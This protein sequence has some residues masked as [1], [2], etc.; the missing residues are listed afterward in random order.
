MGFKK[1][2][3][4]T[5]HAKILLIDDDPDMR[6]AMRNILADA[7]FSVAEA[8]AGGVGLEIAS[9]RTPDTVLLDMRMPGLGG[10]E[11]LRRLR[12]LDPTLPVII[13]TAHGTISGAVSAV[14]DGAFDYLTKPFRNEHLLDTVQRAVAR[15]NAAHS[16]ATGVCAAV[17]RDDGAR[18]CHPEVGRADRGRHLDRLFRRHPRGDRYR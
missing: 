1:N 8:E 10:E 5:Q 11:V 15:R 14:R 12:R 3:I 4:D 9:R 6:W 18:S 2:S 7:G 13:V 17:T 16:V